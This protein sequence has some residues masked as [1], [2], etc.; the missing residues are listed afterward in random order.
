MQVPDVNVVSI[1]CLHALS[2]LQQRD[3]SLVHLGKQRSPILSHVN[4][5]PVPG[6]SDYF[7][8]V[9]LLPCQVMRIPVFPDL[10]TEYCSKQVPEFDR[11]LP[12]RWDRAGNEDV[13]GPQQSLH[14]IVR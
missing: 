14:C 5:Q 11:N 8:G 1:L 6:F 13:L 3:F 9:S 4:S 7:S 12:F 10:P 2:S